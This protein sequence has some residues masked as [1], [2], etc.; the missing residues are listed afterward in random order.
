MIEWPPA[1]WGVHLWLFWWPELLD[2]Q[3]EPQCF[4]GAFWQSCS[5]LPVP[6]ETKVPTAWNTNAAL[7][8][9]SATVIFTWHGFRMLW[10]WLWDGERLRKIAGKGETGENYTTITYYNVVRTCTC[11]RACPLVTSLVWP[12]IR[13]VRTSRTGKWL[14][15]CQQ[16]VEGP[17]TPGSTSAQCP[18]EVRR[19]G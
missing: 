19:E 17:P 15:E 4:A 8:V 13:M 6:L 12:L 10:I 11:I 2:E 18:T 3:A 9:A 14:L 1:F 7:V 5:G 16:E